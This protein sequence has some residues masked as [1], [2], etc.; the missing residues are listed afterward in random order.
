MR[1]VI[2]MQGAQSSSRPRGIGRYALQFAK[3]FV[4]IAQPNHEVLFALN[5]AF[6]DS[7]DWLELELA[8]LLVKKQ[9]RIFRPV[10]PCHA[11][12]ESNAWRRRTSGLLYENFIA[13]LKPDFLIITSLFE[14]QG[15]DAVSSIGQLE[16]DY[17]VAV[18][19]HDLIP[20]LNPKTHLDSDLRKKWYYHNINSLRHS[21]LFLTNSVSSKREALAYLSWPAKHTSVVYAA[22]D[23]YFKL[24]NLSSENVSKCLFNLNIN[25]PFVM[26]AGAFDPHKNVKRLIAAFANLPIFVRSK[27]QLV[28]V[29]SIDEGTRKHLVAFAAEQ[30]LEEAQLVFPGWVS[31]EDLVA[32]YNTCALF[33]LPSLHEGFGL[34]ALEAMACGAPTLASNTTSLPEVVGWDEALFDPLDVNDMAR[35]IEQ[36]L[37]DATFRQALR[38]HGL[39]QSKKFSWQS[40]AQRALEAL[41]NWHANHPIQHA[42]KLPTDRPYR[43]R[44]AYFSPLQPARSGIAGYSTAL[45]PELSRYYAIDVIVQ[46]DEAVTDP[47]VLGNAPIRSVAW[48]EQNAHVFDRVLYHFGNSEFHAHMFDLIQ[49]HPGVIVLHDFFLSGVQAW[50]LEAQQPGVWL[51]SLLESHGYSALVDWKNSKDSSEIVMRYPC[52]LGVLQSPFGV[53]VHADYSRHLA[54][55]FY[56]AGFADDWRLIKHLR[57]PAA[58][59]DRANARSELGI[60][61]DAFVVCS[62]GFLDATKL[63]HRLLAAWRKSKLAQDLHCKLV[64]VG[65]NQVGDYG[66]EMQLSVKAMYG[67]ASIT[68]YVDE[69]TSRLYLQAADA[70]LQLK[71]HSSG[72][73]LTEVLNCMNFG[74]PTI[75]NADGSMAE[76]P[77]DAVVMLPDAFTDDELTHALESL[78]RDAQLRASLGQKAR[79][80]I[81]EQ[82]DPRHCARQYAEAIEDYYDQAKQGMLGLVQSIRRLD[83][84]A[85]P[86]DISRLAQRAAELHPMNRPKCKQ[87]L[88][89]ISELA[90]RDA[91][92]GIQR[93]V[94]S[95]LH[96]LL[97]NPPE[98]FRVEPIYATTEH[99]YRYARHFTA[100]FLELGE[101]P[102]RDQ[103]VDIAAGD[104]FWAV[105]LQGHIVTQ[106]WHELAEWRQ[107]GVKVY[108]TVYDLLPLIQAEVFVEN[109]SHRRWM[110]AIAHADGLI[111]ISESVMH[112]VEE[113]LTAFGPQTSHPV[114]LGWT[115]LGADVNKSVE[116]LE[117]PSRKQ[118]Q[119]LSAI[120]RHPS[121]L[122]VGTLEPRKMQ[123]QAL[124]A[125]EWLWRQGV[126]A[127]LVIVGKAGWKTE[128]L[129]ER[130]RQH[131]ENGRHLFWLEGISDA[132][133]EQVYQASACLIAASKNEGFGLP[134]IEAAMRGLPIIARD[135]PVFREV[136]G[137]RALYFSGYAPQNLGQAVQHWLDLQS[138]GEAPQSTGM[139][140]M[141]W[142]QA[143][144]KMLDVILHDQWQCEWQPKKDASLVAR[145]WGSDDRL[146]TLVGARMGRSLISTGNAGHML[147]EPYITLKPGNYVAELRGSIGQAGAGDAQADICADGGKT[148]FVDRLLPSQADENGVIARLPFTLKEQKND[149]EVRIEVS[150][151]SDVQLDELVI[152]RASRNESGTQMVV[153]ESET[154]PDGQVWS[155]WGSH[156]KIHTE[157]GVRIGRQMVSTGKAGYLVYGPYMS[158]P[159]GI[160]KAKIAISIAGESGALLG[161]FIDVCWG[162]GKIRS[163]IA[164]FD[165]LHLIQNIYVFETF[166]KLEAFVDDLEVRLFI[167]ELVLVIFVDTVSI[168]FER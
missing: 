20:L 60:A 105:D 38:E 150:E 26:F 5:G 55:Q 90:Q 28:L 130:L 23:S 67:Q 24:L 82:H 107:Q 102:L 3:A 151:H 140:W 59:I 161:A 53:I 71:S 127:N 115:H 142:A 10:S 138:K 41:E 51:Q 112:D 100:R 124:A 160:Y 62:F 61:P 168:S 129:A 34:P 6:N 63:N 52:N 126:Q 111:S 54:A 30:G 74:L 37:T 94:R 125:F 114:K 50:V 104:V 81:H 76:L 147:H 95:V 18:V 97:L 117:P 156:P 32:L 116:G 120:R 85:D 139:P 22:A 78:W 162:H 14:G 137:E 35:K 56:G 98:G 40:T 159:S 69:A 7:L 21:D 145:Y 132:Y 164:A 92:T 42:Q 118:A 70:A 84:P 17:H 43:P 153:D 1:I 16:R 148:V 110:E 133:L 96:E 122:L 113:W 64:F 149:L 80:Y 4:Q 88:L 157:F 143:T 31:D 65:Q 108:F 165:P 93:V 45:L 167:P 141:T 134:L 12:D 49:R 166:F 86:Q 27:H 146:V 91:K 15:D 119:Q 135:I 73:N 29:H 83:A 58:V 106:H 11:L 152:R 99:G 66:A 44:L 136:C 72:E 46:Q 33:V 103:P 48:F 13:T 101:L 75:V 39:R 121:F 68:G 144:T 57:V 79:A 163:D 19:L 8:G 2:D 158:L 131:P 47:W 154:Q 123:D 128:E 25:K 9:F 109:S 155:W 87:L 36:A 77:H 89:D